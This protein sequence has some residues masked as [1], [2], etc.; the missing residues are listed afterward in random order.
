M[1]APYLAEQMFV[2]TYWYEPFSLFSSW[3]LGLEI[4]PSI[5]GTFPYSV[6]WQGD[7]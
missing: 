4:Y 3:E 1:W 6:E 2:D 7:L 5:L